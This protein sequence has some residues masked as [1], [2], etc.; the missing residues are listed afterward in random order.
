[1]QALLFQVLQ[2]T[3]TVAGQHMSDAVRQLSFITPDKIAPIFTTSFAM[4]HSKACRLYPTYV[5]LFT[6]AK[7]FV[8][9]LQTA[10]AT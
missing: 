7:A 3:A 5:T 10:L 9:T 6:F 1:M 8:H 2:L 4:L